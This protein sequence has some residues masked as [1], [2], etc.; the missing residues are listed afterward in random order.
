MRPSYPR[1]KIRAL[2]ESAVRYLYGHRGIFVRKRAAIRLALIAFVITVA[3]FNSKKSDPDL[4]QQILDRGEI[5][6]G[7]RLGPLTY[8]ERDDV[9]GGLDYYI[10]KA[11]ADSYGLRLNHQIIDDFSD[12][13]QQVESGNID[14]AAASLA[15][16]EQRLEQVGF[17]EPYLEVNTV[18][19]QHSS[20]AVSYTH[21]TLPTICSV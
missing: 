13:L 18:V 1:H 2:A 14:I 4:F 5:N 21:L 7:F 20:K 12:M 15:I 3:F 9:A 16:T 11:F 8:Y 17:S 6:I 10:L 19:I